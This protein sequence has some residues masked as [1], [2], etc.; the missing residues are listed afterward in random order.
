MLVDPKVPVFVQVHKV[1]RHLFF[2]DRT[3]LSLE[4]AQFIF[5]HFGRELVVHDVLERC[6]ADRRKPRPFLG[7]ADGRVRLDVQLVPA[8]GVVV[9]GLELGYQY[10]VARDGVGWEDLLVKLLQVH[11]PGLVED[12][13]V[14]GRYVHGLVALV[15][16]TDD[17]LVVFVV[18]R[19]QLAFVKTQR[20]EGQTLPEEL[21]V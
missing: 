4:L 15:L 6:Q 16:L 3:V 1:V 21:V 14:V 10:V 7:R 8:H 13:D 9:V 5:Q 19:I 20:Y 11:D 2:V 18:K 17:E 12:L